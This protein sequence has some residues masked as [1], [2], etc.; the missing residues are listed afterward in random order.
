MGAKEAS[1]HLLAQDAMFVDVRPLAA[2]KEAN[3]PTSY[4]LPAERELSDYDMK[5][6]KERPLLIVYGPD[7]A[8]QAVATKL[9]AKGLK[10][11]ILQDGLEGW[12]AAGMP[13]TTAV[14]A[15]QE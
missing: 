2:F 5:R 9:A 8:A 3:I 6:L 13:V 14:P 1:K 11:V 12:R 15:L 7:Q 10:V 4:S